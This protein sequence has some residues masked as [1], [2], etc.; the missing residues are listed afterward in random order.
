[1]HALKA[2]QWCLS[3]SSSH[4][5]EFKNTQMPLD[6]WYLI[7]IYYDTDTQVYYC[8]YAYMYIQRSGV[9]C[10]YVFH[11]LS[12]C[13]RHPYDHVHDY[14]YKRVFGAQYNSCTLYTLCHPAYKWSKQIRW[15]HA[16]FTYINYTFHHKNKEFCLI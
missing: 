4:S 9:W 14:R 2:M 10:L 13:T 3:W 12:R 6:K 7:V 15:T 11:V 5:Y 1:M 16:L 8:V